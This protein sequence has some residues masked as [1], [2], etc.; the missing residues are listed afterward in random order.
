[1]SLFE[2]NRNLLYELLP[3]GNSSSSTKHL[4]GY[5]YALVEMGALESKVRDRLNQRFEGQLYPLITEAGFEELTP[6][7]ASLIAAPVA[8][9]EGQHRL[10]NSLDEYSSDVIRAWITSPLSALELASHF[11]QATFAYDEQGQRYLLRYYDPFVLPILY[12]EAPEYW[13]RWFFAPIISWRFARPYAH[14]EQWY[15]LKGYA[16]AAL[17]TAPRFVLTTELLEALPTPD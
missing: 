10:V 5:L 8:D 3:N 11:R 2:Q 14:D 7:G 15:Q 6:L 13:Q 12:G 16:S 1:M 17:V 4:K 9:W